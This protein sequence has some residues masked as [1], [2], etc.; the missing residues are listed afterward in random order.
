MNPVF[1]VAGWKPVKGFEPMME[2]FGAMATDANPGVQGF[3]PTPYKTELVGD[4]VLV[5]EDIKTAKAEFKGLAIHHFDK[6]TGK[7]YLCVP[8]HD[9]AKMS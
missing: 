9:S 1:P 7:C 6:D 8:Y 2:Q 3:A 4:K 5:F